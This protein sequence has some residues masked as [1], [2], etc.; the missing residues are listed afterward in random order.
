MVAS[1]IEGVG[2]Y[3]NVLPYTGSDASNKC[4]LSPEMEVIDCQSGHSLDD[5]AHDWIV[6][7]WESRSE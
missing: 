1:D 2:R 5:W 7:D 4:L 6:E 3:G